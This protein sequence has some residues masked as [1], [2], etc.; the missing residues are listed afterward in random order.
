MR[1]F[2]CI[3]IIDKHRETLA[4]TAVRVR[5]TTTM[6]ANWVSQDNYHI[7][8]RFLG[9]TDPALIVDLDHLCCDLAERIEPFECTLDRL[10]AFPSVD[11][12][13]VL[14]AGGDI[15]PSF[16]RLSMGLSD[17][18]ADLGFPQAKKDSV[19]HVTLARIKD[20]PDPPLGR[21]IEALGPLKPMYVTIDRLVLMESMLTAQGAVYTPLF[22]TRLGAFRT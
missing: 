21:A 18:L 6:K 13:R 5:S 1:T 16:Q 3:P 2:F 15:H 19:V 8:L 12:A 17:G 9:D 10:G 11:R 20:V 22:T 7:T 14:W 4:H